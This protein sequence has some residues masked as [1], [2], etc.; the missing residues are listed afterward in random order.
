MK[1]GLED[2]GLY[3]SLELDGLVVHEQG[4]G[5]FEHHQRGYA[6]GHNLAELENRRC[7]VRSRQMSEL[8]AFGVHVAWH[9]WAC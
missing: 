6:G 3:A 1:H 9:V 2:L 4:G 7:A 8:D 5:S